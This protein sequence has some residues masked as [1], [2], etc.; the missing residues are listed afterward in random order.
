MQ[1]RIRVANALGSRIR[2]F[3]FQIEP[4]GKIRVSGPPA[5]R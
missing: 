1:R 5:V 4:V 2:A 3:P